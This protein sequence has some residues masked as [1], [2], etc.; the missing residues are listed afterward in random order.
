MQITV[1]GKPQEILISTV[2]LSKSKTDPT[3]IYMFHCYNCASP[4]H[5][6]Q[7]EATSIHAGLVP[8]DNVV[9]VTQCRE[10]K[11]N[12]TFLTTKYQ[13][14]V[15]KLTLFYE[16][17]H[18]AFHCPICR[19]PLVRYNADYAVILPRKIVE[20][21]PEDFQCI[22]QTCNRFYQLEEIVYI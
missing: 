14:P 9:V 16:K 2:L 20:E 1:H 3:N 18:E 6:I 13:T 17:G 7:G 12:Y 19:S 11:S 5:K 21:F 8:N 15:T 10:C 22:N 4:L